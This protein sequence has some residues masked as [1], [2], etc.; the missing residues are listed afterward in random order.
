MSD[1]SFGLI[2]KL[3]L[4]YKFGP[5]NVTACCVFSVSVLFMSGNWWCKLLW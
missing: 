2:G 3:N 4:E 5:V 1:F